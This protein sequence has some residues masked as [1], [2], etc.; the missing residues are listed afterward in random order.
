MKNNLNNNNSFLKNALILIS[1]FKK[2]LIFIFVSMILTAAVATIMPIINMTIVDEGIVASNLRV[3]I[4]MLIISAS[5]FILGRVLEFLQFREFVK[6]N[7]IFYFRLLSKAQNHLMKLPKKYFD[8]KNEMQILNDIRMDL[9]KITLL[10]D[11]FLLMSIIQIFIVVGSIIGLFI[12]NPLLLLI[13][14]AAAPIK[15]FTIRF[16]ANRHEKIMKKLLDAYTN[17]NNIIGDGFKNI[18]LIKLWGLRSRKLKEFRY[19][20]KDI[21]HSQIDM[22]YNNNFNENA[23]A[24]LN[25]IINIIVYVVGFFSILNGTLTIGGIFAFMTYTNQIL[26]PIS[27]ISRIQHLFADIKPSLK[28][29]IEFLELVE[30]SPNSKNKKI[31]IPNKITFS[32]VSLKYNN[33]S[34]NMAL[35]D[36]DIEIKRGQKIAFVGENGSGKSSVLSLLLRLYEPSFG[37]I[38]FDG[39]DI[40]DYNIYEYRNLFSVISQ[41]I[42]FFNKNIK[43]NIDPLGKLDYDDIK[44]LFKLYN[45]NDLLEEL[46]DGLD[47]HMGNNSAKLSGGQAQ[48]I[49]ALRAFAKNSKILILDEATS[50]YDLK[51]EINF[52]EIISSC[53]GFE[54]IFIITH[55]KSILNSCDIIIELDNGRIKDGVH[56]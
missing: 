48:K 53:E 7:K 40:Q 1:P 43:E 32:K 49:S 54:Y 46:P 14:V 34:D 42:Q 47:T 15:F 45:F 11:R 37:R 52:N 6:I 12:I 56:R 13:I 5:L 17:F 2:K 22:E 10:T 30:E 20:Q 4:R 55:Q 9:G 26:N 41:D 29:H 16:F 8:E 21:I 3:L 28:R 19:K 33:N 31:K 51:S 44:E 25:F 27:F 38:L 50:K 23:D 39:C 24:F 36:V 35:K 18:V